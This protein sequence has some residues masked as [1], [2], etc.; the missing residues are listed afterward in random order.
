MTLYQ[1]YNAVQRRQISSVHILPEETANVNLR[2]TRVI[3]QKTENWVYA[4]N[5]FNTHLHAM[6][7]FTTRSND[8]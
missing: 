6:L 7:F 4:V 1:A 2:T 8:L 5:V 3:P